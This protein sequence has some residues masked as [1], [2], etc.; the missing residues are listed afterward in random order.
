MSELK[1]ILIVDDDVQ[2]VEMLSMI[3]QDKGYEVIPAYVGELGY[4]KALEHRPDIILLDI[5]LP[6]MD[7]Y[8][9]CE[10]IKHNPETSDIPVVMLTGKDMGESFDRAMEKKADWYVVKPYN[11]EHLMKV[12]EK[13]AD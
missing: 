7:G 5:T 3:L 12:F 1:K 10:Q 9:V 6:G 13:L 8:Q 4:K 2:A 11:I